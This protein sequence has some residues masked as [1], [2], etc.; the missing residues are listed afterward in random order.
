MKKRLQITE[1]WLRDI[2]VYIE[3]D[4]SK[5]DLLERILDEHENSFHNYDEIIYDLEENGIKITKIDDNDS[6]FDFEENEI[7]DE[8]NID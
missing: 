6:L 3:L 7:I 1:K 8:I 2:F 5:Q 4:E